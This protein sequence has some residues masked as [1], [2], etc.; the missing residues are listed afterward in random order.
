MALPGFVEN[1]LTSVF[2]GVRGNAVLSLIAFLLFA[3]SVLASS[4]SANL[5]SIDT[6]WL[7]SHRNVGILLLTIGAY[8]ALQELVFPWL[9][10]FAGFPLAV[11][12]EL[13]I[14]R[15]LRRHGIRAG[16]RDEDLL[17]YSIVKDKSVAYSEY[18][19]RIGDRAALFK[20]TEL[21]LGI[22]ALSAANL[23]IDT[24]ASI[25]KIAVAWAMELP[26]V[27]FVLVVFSLASAA[28]QLVG[29][30]LFA[31]SRFGVRYF[32]IWNKKLYEDMEGFFELE[33]E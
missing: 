4:F 33:Q 27:P 16:V 12:L 31:S 20:A 15:F 6:A 23:V 1:S 2:S 9:R 11:V 26:P 13:L 8:F 14:Y 5:L 32:S 24:K 3:D 25:L 28:F 21:S 18:I 30:M 29:C 19:R 22:L 7:N 10:V 17:I